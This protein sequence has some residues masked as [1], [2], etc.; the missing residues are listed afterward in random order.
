MCSSPCSNLIRLESHSFVQVKRKLLSVLQIQSV[1]IL[2]TNRR[3][4]VNQPDFILLYLFHGWADSPCCYSK[5]ECTAIHCRFRNI[6][7]DWKCCRFGWVFCRK[8]DWEFS[9]AHVDLADTYVGN[10]S[11]AFYWMKRRKLEVFIFS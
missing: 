2:L 10:T 8:N 6:E 9:R 3:R 5:I 1:G 7:Q 11:L 4:P